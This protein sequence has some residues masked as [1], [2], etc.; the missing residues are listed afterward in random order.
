[1]AIELNFTSL[2][3]EDG[4]K[5]G[6]GRYLSNAPVSSVVNGVLPDPQ[7]RILINQIEQRTG[8]D[9][10]SAPK[11]TTESGRHLHIGTSDRDSLLF[12]LRVDKVEDCGLQCGSKFSPRSD[13]A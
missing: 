6:L 3:E 12:P 9:I 1:M 5:L 11:A 2:P 13:Y 7:F 4:S 10:L 8:T